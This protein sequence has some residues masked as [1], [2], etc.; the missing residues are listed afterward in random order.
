[1]IPEGWG[2][3]IDGGFWELLGSF[4]VG[5]AFSFASMVNEVWE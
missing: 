4:I 5:T 3:I 2:V 1:V